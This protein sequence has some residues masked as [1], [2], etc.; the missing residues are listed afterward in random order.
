MPAI[1]ANSRRSLSVIPDPRLLLLLLDLRDLEF[2]LLA[3]VLFEDALFRDA[4]DDPLL[5]L[6]P[7]REE[8][9]AGAR[10]AE[11]RLRNRPSGLL[12]AFLARLLARRLFAGDI[13]DIFRVKK[14]KC[15]FSF[16]LVRKIFFISG[17]KN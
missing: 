9:F 10:F 11:V 3:L 4:F 2:L 8:D 12:G 15:L 1:L 17:P 13:P 16:R 7:R 14:G 6:D 5:A